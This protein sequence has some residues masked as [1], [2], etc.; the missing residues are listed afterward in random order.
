MH[1]WE[2]RPLRLDDL[3]DH[4]G[5]LGRS[6]RLTL[7]VNQESGLA[8]SQVCLEAAIVRG[9]SDMKEQ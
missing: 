6:C 5:K 8:I 1:T 9:N 4:A 7:A 2:I 3:D